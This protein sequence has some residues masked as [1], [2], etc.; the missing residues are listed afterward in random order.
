MNYH[1]NNINDPNYDEAFTLMTLLLNI[2]AAA[3]ATNDK[4]DKGYAKSKAR[5]TLLKDMSFSQVTIIV[6]GKAHALLLGGPQMQGLHLMIEHIALENG[7]N[8]N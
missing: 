1:I 2:E 5:N 6:N 3:K 4:N 7:Y 8:V